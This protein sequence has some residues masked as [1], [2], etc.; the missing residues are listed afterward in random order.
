MVP[1][2]PGEQN[3]MEGETEVSSAF[4]E[5]TGAAVDFLH[6]HDL[7]NFSKQES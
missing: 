5:K 1:E 3:Q 6:F 2:L 4:F 7:D